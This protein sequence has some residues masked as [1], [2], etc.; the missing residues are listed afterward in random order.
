MRTFK[1]FITALFLLYHVSNAYAQA[2]ALVTF[3]APEDMEI[4]AESVTHG[5][6][7]EYVDKI[8]EALNAH[9]NVTYGSL[10]AASGGKK[11][12]AMVVSDTM[13]DDELITALRKHHAVLSAR[14]NMKVRTMN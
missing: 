7:R 2:Q 5:Q 4:T 9:V 3:K 6:A 10:S 12:L 8:A 1:L 14:P 13:T 11:I